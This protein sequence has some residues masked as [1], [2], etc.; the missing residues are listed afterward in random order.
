MRVSQVAVERPVT[1]LMIFFGVLVI[2]GFCL[3]QLPI[4]LLPE[5]DLPAIS[6]VTRYPGAAAEDVETKVT[7]IL[8]DR[9]ATVPD[10]KHILSTSKEGVSLIQLAFEWGTDLD[11]RANDVRDRIGL[12]EIDLPEDVEKPL[13][14]KINMSD[15]PILVYG[16]SATESLP[17]LKRIVEDQIADPLKRLPGVGAVVIRGA[18]ER[19]VNIH[20]DRQRL[21]SYGLTPQDIVRVV[22]LEN[23]TIPAGDIKE[24]LTDYMVRVPGEFKSVEPMK[25]I[26]I[27]SRNGSVVRL[28]DVA[29]VEFGHEEAT[30]LVHVNGRRG[31]IF[32]IQRQSGANTVQVARRV[33]RRLDELRKSLPPDVVVVNAM[34]ASEDI[35]RTIKDL[36]QTLLIGGGLAVL[37]VLVFLR[38][39]RATFVIA[40]TIPFSLVLTIIAV[41]FLG[42]TINMMTLFGMTI[43]VG[44]VVDNAIVVLENISRHREEGERPRE[45]AVYGAREVGMAITASTLTTVCIFFPIL[46][47]KGITKILFS[48]FAAVVSVVILSSLFCALTLTPMLSA[49]LLRRGGGGRFFQISER[50]FEAFAERYAALLGWALHHRWLVVV[51]AVALFAGSL[52]VIPLVGSEF[53]PEEDRAIFRGFVHLPVGTRVEETA[54]VMEEIESILRE[55]IPESAREMIYWRCGQSKEAIASVFGEEGPHIGEFGVKLVPKTQRDRT[56]KEL[57]EAVRKRLEAIRGPNRMVKLRLDTADPMAGMILGS[58]QPLSVDILGDDMEATDKLAEKFKKILEATPGAVDV[59]VSRVKG[60]PELWV[61]VD[62]DRA[63][64]LGLNVFQ[65]ADTI[66]ASYYGRKATKYRVGGNEYDIFVRLREEDRTRVAELVHTPIRL[67]GGGL[68]Q[69]GNLASVELRL[70]PVEIERKD[71]GR[72]VSVGANVRGRSLGEVTADFER[73]LA[74]IPIPSGV[75]IEMAGQTEEQR[76]SFF[77]LTLAL[78]IGVVLVYM[79]MASQFESLVDPFVIMFSV[80]FAFVG[81][82]WAMF[83]GGHNL[84]IIV[85]IGL[86]MLVGIVVNNAIVLVDYTNI[87]RA[88]GLSLFEA[89]QQAGRTRLRPVLMT[90][91]TTIVALLPMAFTRGQGSEVWN[92]LGLTVL[93]GLLVSTLITLVLVPTIYT[94]F[95][96]GR[97]S[98]ER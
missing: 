48:E 63:S 73:R 21:A 5:M 66:R 67:P 91:L 12:A 88:R 57:A 41:Y 64:A 87:L 45:A 68:V 38:Q 78:G 39:V 20:F 1:T 31:L 62:R 51:V 27:A 35:I 77:W 19:Q 89:V 92:P 94:I 52:L 32:F 81:V 93:G 65:I 98:E 83:L 28:S 26:V 40:L 95:E 6:V 4:D 61:R 34:D 14:F 3:T 23:Q 17:D 33:H 79:V 53:M 84:S 49:R 56:V 13:V 59:T 15:M 86:L 90:A 58:A 18:V 69:V 50:A 43:G 42:Y 22:S 29:T 30:Q 80:P 24:G 2:G 10:I 70:G 97:W 9:I 44:M 72:K 8:E 54:R 71:Q 25:R 82:I 85:F 76:E 7:E 46:F 74:T 16:V 75:E 11:T 96:R 37:A 36:R 55:E 47:V 60:R